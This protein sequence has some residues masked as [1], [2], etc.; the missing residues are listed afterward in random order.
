MGQGRGKLSFDF[1]ANAATSPLCWR[2]QRRRRLGARLVRTEP[3]SEPISIGSA[4]LT[5]RERNELERC[6]AQAFKRA[7]E[8]TDALTHERL[9][10]VIEDLE[11]KLL[12]PRL[13]L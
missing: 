6:L 1:F 12:A 2:S 3:I 8:P 9:A 4:E 11:F 5:R 7:L 13:A 10:Q